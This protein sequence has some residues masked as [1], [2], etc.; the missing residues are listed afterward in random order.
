LLKKVLLFAKAGISGRGRKREESS[1]FAELH[2]G[3]PSPGGGRTGRGKPTPVFPP[4]G[5]GEW[6]RDADR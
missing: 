1:I 2:L 5:G 6:N 3:V 4:P